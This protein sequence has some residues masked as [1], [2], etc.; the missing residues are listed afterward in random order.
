MEYGVALLLL[1]WLLLSAVNQLPLEK[2]T[3]VLR[4]VDLFHLIPRWHFFAPKPAVFDFHFAVRLFAPEGQVIRDWTL[5]SEVPRRT[6]LAALWNPVRR[7][8]KMRADAV[9]SLMR[10][11]HGLD[12]NSQRLAVISLPYLLLLNHA[13]NRSR[14]E[15]ASF[16]QFA[17]LTAG[18]F[19]SDGGSKVLIRSELHA[20]DA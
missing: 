19:V 3:S 15:N 4:R 6:A 16:V 13:C 5:I 10:T 2:I 11:A 17:V 14:D 9:Q 8:R 12:E 1:L 18:G 20:I 7:E